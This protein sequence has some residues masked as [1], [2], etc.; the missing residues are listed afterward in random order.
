MS[1]NLSEDLVVDR[2]F[3]IVRPKLNDGALGRLKAVCGRTGL[4]ALEGELGAVIALLDRDLADF[5]A[6]LLALRGGPTAVGRSARHLLDAG[7]KRLRPL[8]VL[9]AARS[10]GREASSARGAELGLAIAAELIH[11]AT[12]L[13]DDVV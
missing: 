8:L 2:E 6:E 10:A 3:S 12:L 5:E 1:A 9:L 13:H 4:P 7:G 11:S